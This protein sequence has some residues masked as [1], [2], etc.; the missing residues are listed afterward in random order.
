MAQSVK[1]SILVV[2]DE[3]AVLTTYGLILSKKGY[4]VETAIS[5]ADAL[6]ALDRRDFDLLLCDYSLEQEHTG[7]EV[8]DYARKKKP[9]VKSAILT[10]YASKET[11]EQAR[12]DGIEILYKP[13][14]IE[15]FFTTIEKLLR[16]DYE[17]HQGLEKEEGER[18][19]ASEEGDAKGSAQLRA[20][21]GANS[22]RRAN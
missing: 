18:S 11:A 3:R 21:R 19:S 14:D 5:S 10:G 8:I 2:D 16:E 20:G 9:G 4:D 12:Q 17:S 13:I 7:F 22:V 6:E 15:E 1:S